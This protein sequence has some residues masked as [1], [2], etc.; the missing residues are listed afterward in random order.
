MLI[1]LVRKNLRMPDFNDTRQDFSLGETL[2]KTLWIFFSRMDVFLGLTLCAT[3]PFCL[4]TLLFVTSLADFNNDTDDILDYVTAHLAICVGY[5]LF[6]AMLSIVLAFAVEAAMV[7]AAAEILAGKSPTWYACLCRGFH[8]F[9][10]L[11]CARVL[12]WFFLISTL[13]LVV[14]FAEALISASVNSYFLVTLL[15]I[16]YV[17]VGFTVWTTT[18][19]LYPV[20]VIENKGPTDGIRRSF[21]LARGQRCYFFCCALCI[22]IARLFV[23]GLLQSFLDDA[24]KVSSLISVAGVIIT[25]FTSSFS[26]PLTSV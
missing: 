6:Q 26:L 17:G 2:G 8:Q 3:L 22:W 23:L 24:S 25:S 1:G 13:A 5:V 15:S 20:I 21:T 18:M 4:T 16:S 14:G 11:A 12:V 7:R 19:I 10:A 9:G